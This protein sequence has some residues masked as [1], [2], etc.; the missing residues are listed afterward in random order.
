MQP[1]R[2]EDCDG[3]K[4]GMSMSLGTKIVSTDS[5]MSHKQGL[6]SRKSKVRTERAQL[7]AKARRHARAAG[8]RVGKDAN[9]F[10]DSHVLF[11][12]FELLREGDNG[13]VYATVFRV[14]S[15][16]LGVGE[17][18]GVLLL[19]WR[20]VSPSSSWISEGRDKE[21]VVV[22][23]V[24]DSLSTQAVSLELD[25]IKQIDRA[26]TKSGSESSSR[27]MAIKEVALS[28]HFSRGKKFERI[29][30]SEIETEVAYVDY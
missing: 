12:G 25:V 23:H 26:H 16:A 1:E 2:T 10:L 15:A 27:K 4:P 22:Q 13:I 6:R 24:S 30:R 7:S 11:A 8:T 14:F 3:S 29:T 5:F 9:P 28:L 18:D 17:R 19:T 21:L 20:H